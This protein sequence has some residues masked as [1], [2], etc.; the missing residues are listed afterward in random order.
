VDVV[1]LAPI[2]MS[3]PLPVDEKLK[4]PAAPIATPEKDG[5]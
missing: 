1:S 5:K 3:P 2:T 4:K